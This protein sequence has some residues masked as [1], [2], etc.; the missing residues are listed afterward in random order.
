MEKVLTKVTSFKVGG[1]WV[2]K[3]AKEELSNI[4]NDLTV[5]ANLDLSLAS[6]PMFLVL[7][8]R[9][10]MRFLSEICGFGHI[11]CNVVG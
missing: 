2:S 5:S 6:C 3:K 10:C 8:L 9:F 1:S 11:L 4:T 7:F